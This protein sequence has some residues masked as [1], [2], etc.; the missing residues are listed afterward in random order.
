MVPCRPL[1]VLE[2]KGPSQDS[3]FTHKDGRVPQYSV[4]EERTAKQVRPIGLGEG[5]RRKVGYVEY[6]GESQQVEQKKES[7]ESGVVRK[8]QE[9]VV[10]ISVESG[11]VRLKG[12]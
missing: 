10:C 8:N 1:F 12:R 7:K 2:L 4:E 5:S 6:V 9:V 3:S 11:K